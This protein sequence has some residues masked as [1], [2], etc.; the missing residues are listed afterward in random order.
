VDS[1]SGRD[2]ER[3]L[4]TRP[5]V[6]ARRA[7]RR[8]AISEL[9]RRNWVLDIAALA[10]LSIL[11]RLPWVLFVH[12][13]ATSDSYFYYLSARSISEGHGY[14]IMGHPTAFFPVGRPSSPACS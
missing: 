1:T 12:G 11:A 7:A 6:D 4:A 13:R 9:I 8:P 3:T 14:A 10:L 5:D 2:G